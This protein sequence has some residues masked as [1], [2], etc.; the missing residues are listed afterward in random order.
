ML[1]EREAAHHCGRKPRQFNIECRVQPVVFPNGDKRYDVRDLDAW[2]DSLKAGDTS[3][4][5]AIV[6]K[7]GA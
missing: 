6:E 5:D 4:A 7:L 1:D 2:L 3:D